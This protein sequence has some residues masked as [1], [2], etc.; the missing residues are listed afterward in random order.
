M[1]L[2]YQEVKKSVHKKI[3]PKIVK[4]LLDYL[5]SFNLPLWGQR[6]PRDFVNKMVYISLYKDLEKVGCNQLEKLLSP[7]IRWN[8]KTL[9]HNCKV[10]RGFFAEWG[11]SKIVQGTLPEWKRIAAG[12]GLDGPV[13]KTNLWIDST[14][15]A[16]TGKK[17]VSRKD[18]SWS[19]KKNSPGR[20]YMVVED[21]ERRVRK[22][23]GGYS[24]KIYDR[25]FIE[26]IK[27]EFRSSFKGATFIADQHFGSCKKFFRDV[28]WIT[29]FEEPPEEEGNPD[30]KDAWQLTAEQKK[31]NLQIKATRSRVESPFGIIKSKFT[32]LDKP[33]AKSPEDLDNLIFFAVGLHNELLQK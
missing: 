5:K 27:E 14:D 21:G 6:R 26:A 17:S 28:E 20:R 1:S 16:L 19:Y 25:N 2:S 12:C 33:F 31:I 9:L 3:P 24:P 15:I 23:W 29:K 10:L 32:V 4:D 30:Q 18:S 22:I 11:K 8:H 7:S 13:A